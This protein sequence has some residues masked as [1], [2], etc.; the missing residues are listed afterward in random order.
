MTWPRSSASRRDARRAGAEGR[1][2]V[3]VDDLAEELGLAPE[4]LDAGGGLGEV[5][6]DDLDGDRGI[7]RN[8]ASSTDGGPPAFAKDLVLVDFVVR[9]KRAELI[10]LPSDPTE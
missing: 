7:E 8:L 1:D 4:P 5:V 2:D 3:A 10:V 9:H 6:A